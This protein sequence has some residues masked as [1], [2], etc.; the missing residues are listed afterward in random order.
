MYAQYRI[1]SIAVL[2]GVRICSY[3]YMLTGVNQCTYRQVLFVLP[4][5]TY[6]S[7]IYRLRGLLLYCST[8]VIV[9]VL[10]EVVIPFFSVCCLP[11][12]LFCRPRRFWN[13]LVWSGAWRQP[14]RGGGVRRRVR[15]RRLCGR[16]W[17]RRWGGVVHYIRVSALTSCC[18][19]TWDVLAPNGSLLSSSLLSS[20]LLS[21]SALVCYDVLVLCLEL[22]QSTRTAVNRTS[23]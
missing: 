8:V 11:F 2:L 9:V 22:V 20:S 5:G 23:L 16:R 4:R 21:C 13:A 19:S 1:I 7:P 14:Y 18:T 3:S 10:V 6:C 17:R 12:C 15:W